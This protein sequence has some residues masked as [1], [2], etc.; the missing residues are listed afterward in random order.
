ML[1]VLVRYEEALEYSAKLISVE[2]NN[3]NYL[4]LRAIVLYLN[5]K[6]VEAMEAIEQAKTKGKSSKVYNPSELYNYYGDGGRAYLYLEQYQKA[7]EFLEE[8][9]KNEISGPRHLGILS[10]AYYHLGDLEKS[11]EYL[12]QLTLNSKT[13]S[14]MVYKAMIYAQREEID[15]AFNYLEQAYQNHEADMWLIKVEPPFE[16]LYDDPR[17]QQMLDKVGFPQ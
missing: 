15:A 10:M 13:I 5:E 17:W 8:G 11:E 1:C 6:P 2:P 12:N 3:R 16:P 9:R 14:P 7:I 4:M